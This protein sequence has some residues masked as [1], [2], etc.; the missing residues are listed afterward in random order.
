MLTYEQVLENNKIM[1]RRHNELV[2]R[3]DSHA[4][5]VEDFSA[6]RYGFAFH[7]LDA[8]TWEQQRDALLAAKADAAAAEAAEAAAAPIKAAAEK[9]AA[10]KAAAEKAEMQ[11][12]SI[13]LQKKQAIEKEAR[14]RI[15]HY[16][17]L[18]REAAEKAIYEE[19]VIAK[20]AEIRAARTAATTAPA[21]S[22]VP[23]RRR[24]EGCRNSVVVSVPVGQATYDFCCPVC[25]YRVT[26]NCF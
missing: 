9:A 18:E 15:E 13:L 4:A 16:E 19:A 24:C 10:E 12:T 6:G 23:S 14:R 22:S 3:Y 17:R 25:S 20:M 5:Y 8:P 21:T 26:T 11:R 7:A 1:F 2:C